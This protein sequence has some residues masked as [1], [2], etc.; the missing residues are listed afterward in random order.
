MKIQRQKLQSTLTGHL[1]ESV[2]E[3][4]T[5]QSFRISPGLAKQMFGLSLKFF[6]LYI[7]RTPPKPQFLLFQ[8]E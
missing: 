7:F 6:F 3:V 4:R 5:G 8:L 2:V 1:L